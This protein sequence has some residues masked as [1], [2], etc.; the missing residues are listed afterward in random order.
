MKQYYAERNGLI[1]DKLSLS[2]DELKTY[3]IHTY[4]YFSDKDYFKLLLMAYMKRTDGGII[5][6]RFCHRQWHLHLKCFLVFTLRIT[7]YDRY[8]NILNS[9][10]KK[11][12]LL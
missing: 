3:F 8:M 2:L 7:R 11:N 12:C 5:G 6:H 1:A 9:M 4:R 10:T